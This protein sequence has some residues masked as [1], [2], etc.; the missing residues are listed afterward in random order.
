ME[1]N[2]FLTLLE[3]AWPFPAVL[4]ALL[5]QDTTL[6]ICQ[7][8]LYPEQVTLPPPLPLQ[9]QAALLRSEMPDFPVHGIRNLWLPKWNLL[10]ALNC[11]PQQKQVKYSVQP[12]LSVPFL[13][14]RQL[15]C[16]KFILLATAFEEV[17]YDD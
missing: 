2:I 3:Q 15:H 4:R 1:R 17:K 13:I 7:Q 11:L 14:S 12:L 16:C 10:D 9:H 6:Q 8:S 5:P